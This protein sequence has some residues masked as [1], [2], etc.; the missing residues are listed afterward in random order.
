LD[1]YLAGFKF[2][3]SKKISDE[4]ALEALGF[5]ETTFLKTFL[6]DSTIWL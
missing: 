4:R 3:P 1:D 5:L 6:K 2:L